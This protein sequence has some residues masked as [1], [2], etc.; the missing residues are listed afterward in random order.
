MYPTIRDAAAAGDD[1][2]KFKTL[3]KSEFA[4]LPAPPTF[5]A[6][7]PG[8]ILA[9]SAQ[10]IPDYRREINRISEKA[11]APVLRVEQ[12]YREVDD[13][14]GQIFR[15]C[16]HMQRGDDLGGVLDREMHT[17]AVT[18]R[19]ALLANVLE[20]SEVDNLCSRS[21]DETAEA[22]RFLEQKSAFVKRTRRAVRK[23]LLQHTGETIDAVL[24]TKN[25]TL[26]KQEQIRL[27]TFADKTAQRAEVF[28]K[29][30]RA[31][32]YQ[33]GG[34]RSDIPPYQFTAWRYL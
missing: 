23:A 34:Y 8:S 24:S 11:L 6:G 14:C 25:L 19:R 28:T 13:Y 17:Y 20:Q 4:S 21:R 15:S 18:V 33:K 31:T 32:Y 22:L 10:T 5:R 16:N 27:K 26:S 1:L 3:V 2:V 12:M 30:Y 9:A 7:T 29:H